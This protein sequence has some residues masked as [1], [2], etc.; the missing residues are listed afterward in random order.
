PPPRGG[1][2][3]LPLE[4]HD[5]RPGRPGAAREAVPRGARARPEA[6]RAAR[7]PRPDLE[8]EEPARR[9]GRVREPRRELLRPDGR[10]RLP[11]LPAPPL[12]LE[13]GRLR[14]SADADGRGAG[15]LPGGA[16]EMGEDVP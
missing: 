14:R 16:A 5:L 10:R 12:R 6:L 2:A 8:R 11:A 15:A 9:P 1:A 7:D 13:R 3:R 4:L